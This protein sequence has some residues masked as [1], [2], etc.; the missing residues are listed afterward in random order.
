MNWTKYSG[1]YLCATGVLHNV[2][3][4]ILGW[5]ILV[6]MNQHGWLASTVING[7]MLFDREAILWFLS[8]GA[9]WVV[10]GLALQSALDQGFKLPRYLGWGFALLA[11]VLIII[12]PQSGA[13]LL[14]VQGGLI[15]LGDKR[16]IAGEDYQQKMLSH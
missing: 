7:Q 4:V 6:L 10:L 16:Q 3:G 2:I 15:I 9:F 14:L 12:V 8:L 1:Y 13:Y 5:P 11:A